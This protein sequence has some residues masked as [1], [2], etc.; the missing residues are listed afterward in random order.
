MLN[1][2]F[3][4]HGFVTTFVATC[5]GR[6]DNRFDLAYV[7]I[8]AMIGV[9]TAKEIIEALG[10]Y[11]AVA[12]LLQK[13]APLVWRWQNRGIPAHEWASVANLEPART[14]GIDLSVL[15]THTAR[16]AARRPAEVA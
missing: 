1:S 3:G 12:A 11:R 10:G 13:P 6:L 15:V 2:H 9:M 14:R 7:A 16:D 4:Y 8:M 5:R